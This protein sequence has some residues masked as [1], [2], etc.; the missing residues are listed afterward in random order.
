MAYKE[1]GAPATDTKLCND[2]VERITPSG[3]AC[4]ER[5][6]P[7][8]ETKLCKVSVERIKPSGPTSNTTPQAS[9]R[10]VQTQCAQ[11]DA[12]RTLKSL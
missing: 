12:L 6:T 5:G 3:L 1:R 7:A 8:T 10:N 9:S 2:S 11:R 4:K